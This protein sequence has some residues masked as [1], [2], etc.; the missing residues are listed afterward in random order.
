[1]EGVYC[2]ILETKSGLE[3]HRVFHHNNTLIYIA[4]HPH[5]PAKCLKIKC[6]K[7]VLNPLSS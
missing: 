6:H 3:C 4:K 5:A 7:V 2:V 1:M